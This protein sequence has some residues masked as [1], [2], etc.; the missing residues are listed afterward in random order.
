[1]I[2]IGV[3]EKI[4][5]TR[6]T[7]P[8]LESFWKVGNLIAVRKD[9]SGRYY[10]SNYERGPLLYA[11]VAQHRPKVI[12]EFGTGR[13]YGSLCMA[14]ALHEQGIDGTIYTVDQRRWRERDPW[15]MDRGNGFATMKLSWA[16]VWPKYFDPAIVGRIRRLTGLSEEVMGDWDRK[17]LPTVDFAYIDAGHDFVSVKHD[18]YSALQVSN[19]TFKMLFDDYVPK[20]GYG[21]R[22]FIDQ[23][24]EKVFETECILTDGQILP[25]EGP[26]APR[27][28]GMVLIDSS[29]VRRNIR[30]AFPDG[31]VEAFLSS[32]RNPIRFRRKF[33]APKRWL[34][35]T[36][37][38][39]VR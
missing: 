23:E 36:M 9:A 18:F 27:G 33:S 28:G 12:L 38:Q 21:V 5:Q 37:K 1:M 26:E 19:P 24:I 25:W 32:H 4:E 30:D 14:R 16:D 3:K 20:P 7:M 35:A 17:G 22:E 39:F 6:V 31:P 8:P 15:E 13:G 2:T 11:L 34:I 10:R 29:R